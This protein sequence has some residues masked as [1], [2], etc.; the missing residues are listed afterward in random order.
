MSKELANGFPT[1][2]EKA[3][4]L[5]K[6]CLQ[7]DHKLAVYVESYLLQNLEDIRSVRYIPKKEDLHPGLIC[8]GQY[9]DQQYYRIKV[10]DHL[11]HN[12]TVNVLFI[13]YGNFA[14]LPLTDIRLLSYEHQTLLTVPPLAVTCFLEGVNVI[15]QWNDEELSTLKKF[16]LYE[17]RQCVFRQLAPNINVVNIFIANAN[18]YLDSMIIENDLGTSIT[19]TKLMIIAKGMMPSSQQYS[20][21]SE[22]NRLRLIQQRANDQQ[23]YG[24]VMPQYE[25][26]V[27]YHTDRLPMPDASSSMQMLNVGT[28]HHVYVSHMEEGPYSFFVQL[29]V[30]MALFYNILFFNLSS[31][32]L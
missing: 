20:D 15:K 5:L 27:N 13:D 19:D 28:T 23:A 6:I 7:K 11:I 12:Q 1:H 3:G 30:I 4:E 2:V 18:K 17:E 14:N 31:V 29:K 16:V 32:K 10:L 25:P 8:I 21:R 24:P 9:D 22:Q 26:P